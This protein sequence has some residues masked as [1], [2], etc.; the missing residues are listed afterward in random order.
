MCEDA[1]TYKPYIYKSRF[2]IEIARQLIE[3]CGKLLRGGQYIRMWCRNSTLMERI[4]IMMPALVGPP[5]LGRNAA[6]V[7]EIILKTSH[8]SI[9]IRC[10]KFMHWKCAYLWQCRPW[11]Y[12]SGF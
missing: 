10:I 6:G 9:F 7:R 12:E 3:V 11:M 2:P 8:I 5:H 1:R 4:A